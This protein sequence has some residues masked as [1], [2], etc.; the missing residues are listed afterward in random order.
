MFFCDSPPFT[1]T[2]K[3]IDILFKSVLFAPALTVFAETES[4]RR[5]LWGRGL[6]LSTI[7]VS[8]PNAINFLLMNA[9]PFPFL[10]TE[11]IGR[12]SC[13]LGQFDPSVLISSLETIVQTLLFF[14]TQAKSAQ[15]QAALATLYTF[16]FTAFATPDSACAAFSD[17]SFATGF[18]GDLFRPELTERMLVLL[19]LLS[20]APLHT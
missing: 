7:V 2:Q 20:A 10:F 3:L 6:I 8:H 4:F 17:L 9:A 16:V 19:S 18:L 13:K 5:V 11:L 15:T 1:V 12:L 14:K